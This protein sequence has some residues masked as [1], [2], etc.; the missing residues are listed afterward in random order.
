MARDARE[1]RRG[2][3]GEQLPHGFEQQ[4]D[5]QRLAQNGDAHGHRD[6]NIRPRFYDN[7]Q[8]RIDGRSRQV[9]QPPLTGM[10]KSSWRRC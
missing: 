5:V 6:V 4:W 1:A 7:R 10:F 8:Q 2:W 9:S 3:L